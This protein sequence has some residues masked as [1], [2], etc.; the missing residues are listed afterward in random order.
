MHA[1]EYGQA[2]TRR[3]VL[4]VLGSLAAGAGAGGG[5]LAAGCAST[6]HSDGPQV[7][8]SKGTELPRTRVPA[9][10]CDSHHH[11]YDSRY[12]WAPEVVL[13]SGDATV[14]DYKKLQQRLGT[15]RNVII[16][17]SG[18]GIDNRLLVESIAAFNGKAR[19]VAVVNAQVT[20]TE[21]QRLNAAGVRG[22]RFNLQQT[23]A[24]TVD[25]VQP[26]ATRIAAMGW[27]VQ[28]NAPTDIIYKAR[29]VWA[30][31]PCPVVFDHL[32]HV[33][34]TSDPVFAMVLGL[35]QSGRGWVKLSGFYIDTKVGPPGYDDQVAVASAYAQAVPGRCVWGSDWPHPTE[36]AEKGV[37][38]DAVLLD[39]FA[40]AVPTEAVRKQ[41]LVDNPSRLYFS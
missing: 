39:A 23:G 9:D 35:M 6:S 8:W 37:P 30:R 21:L 22:I 3:N 20:D 24:T 29:D 36:Q 2:I 16:Q 12:P 4:K 31:L 19:G 14:A 17:P 7:K 13:K 25:M 33:N 18:Y 1:K 28:I 38:D 10:A 40:R 11:I 41:I 5:L 27:H 15:T 32:A 34:Q 26:L